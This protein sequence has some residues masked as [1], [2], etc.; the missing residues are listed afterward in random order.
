M[1][2]VVQIWCAHPCHDEIL[3]NGKKRFWK[4]GSKPSHPKGKRFIKHDLAEFINSHHQAIIDG[5]SNQLSEGD[6]LCTWCFAMEEKR[7][8]SKE[9]KMEIE[10]YQPSAEEEESDDDID[11]DIDYYVDHEEDDNA[12]DE[13]IVARNKLNQVFQL[14]DVKKID[15]M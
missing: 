11:D 6:Y 7:F 9:E 13:R 12:L 10:N 1:P 14:L 15:D 2:R 8:I 5:S 3:P 4:T